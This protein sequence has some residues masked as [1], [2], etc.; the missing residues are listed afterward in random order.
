MCGWPCALVDAHLKMLRNAR[1]TSC[2][3]PAVKSLEGKIT[4]YA[5]SL[6]LEQEAFIMQYKEVGPKDDE[7]K[8]L[9]KL[10]K[11]H[12][13]IKRV[14]DETVCQLCDYDADDDPHSFNCPTDFGAGD[15]PYGMKLVVRE[16]SL[17]W[18]S[19]QYTTAF[20]GLPCRHILCGNI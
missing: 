8:G 4:P 2:S 16:C 12:H 7:A 9:R 18:C 5:L 14:G 10:R 20:G 6:V 15:A 1:N 13:W 19:C 11:G 3:T 17:D